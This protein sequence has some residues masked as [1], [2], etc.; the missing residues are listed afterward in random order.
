[1][2]NNVRVRFAPSPTGSL[3]VGGVRVAFFNWLLARHHGGAF[4]LRIEDTDRE[5]SRSEYTQDIL[6]SLAWLGM[7]SDEPVVYQSERLAVYGQLI[8]QL[9]RDG[10]AYKCFCTP[11]ELAQRLVHHEGGVH[12]DRHCRGAAS[13]DDG[14]AYVVR[15]A[16]PEQPEVVTFNDLVLGPICVNT[17]QL[18]DFIIARSDG[19]PIYNFVVVADDV[20]MHI[21]H[22]LRGQ[23]HISNTP[24]QILLYRALNAQVPYFV[25]LPMILGESGKKL[26]KRDAAT[27]VT[28][29][30]RAGYLP[31]ALLNYLVRLSWA[32]G[33]QEIFS[34]HELIQL[35]DLNGIGKSDPV[36]DVVKLDWV[37]AQ[38]MKCMSASDILAVILRDVDVEFAKHMVNWNVVQIEKAIDLYKERISTLGQLVANIQALYKRPERY[39]EQAYN[40]LMTHETRQQLAQVVVCLQEL[41]NWQEC[42]IVAAIK[43]LVTQLHVP[44]AQVAQPLRLALT[45]T[46][47]SPGIGGLLALLGKEESINRVRE[48]I[49]DVKIQ[50]G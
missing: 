1:M 47:T 10:K 50:S 2:A 23:D 42:V 41:A 45:G 21:T 11:D 39:D 7:T 22:V 12:Y 43:Q 32:H 37:N 49:E 18:D 17:D 35:F 38:Y 15:L 24:K 4:L 31:Y 36:F 16:L 20:A 25:H 33:D 9:V 44:F 13:H 28:D 8:E 29:Y 48:L 46:L 26:S 19:W 6:E 5:R 3:H 40:Q 34:R 27:A 14:R 30:R